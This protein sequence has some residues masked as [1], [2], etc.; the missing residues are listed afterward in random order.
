[1]CTIDFLIAHYKLL[2]KL[3]YTYKVEARL[4]RPLISLNL[5]NLSTTVTVALESLEIN[6]GKIRYTGSKLLSHLQPSIH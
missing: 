4:I 2:N 1:M 3:S 5:T 6:Y